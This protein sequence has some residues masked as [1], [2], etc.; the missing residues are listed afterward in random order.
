M[1]VSTC[2]ANHGPDEASLAAT[3]ACRAVLEEGCI[4]LLVDLLTTAPGSEQQQLTAS[5]LYKVAV[6]ESAVAEAVVAAHP[7][8]ALVGLL[9]SDQ[10]ALQRNA[11]VLLELLADQVAAFRADVL[12]A[13][14]VPILVQLVRSCEDEGTQERAAGL[15][16]TLAADKEARATI[17]KAGGVQA[18]ERLRCDRE[19]PDVIKMATGALRALRQ[20]DGQ[21]ENCQ[22]GT[23]SP[24]ASDTRQVSATA[25]RCHCWYASAGGSVAAA[26][27]YSCL[28]LRASRCNHH[29]CCCCTPAWP[30]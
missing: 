27:A 7:A 3:V 5:L 23:A 11:V 9:T 8:P 21:E 4:P 17:H 1:T 14:A 26:A 24:A 2:Q 18:L 20:D 16:W 28:W 29:H 12:A 22:E 25:W 10:Q 13:G 30:F 19:D 6:R 15:M